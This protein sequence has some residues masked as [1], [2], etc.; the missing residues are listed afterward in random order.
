MSTYIMRWNPAISSSKI[1]EFR[2]AR[3]KWP[4][5]FCGDWSIYEWENAHARDKYIMVRVGDEP[6]G[7]VYHGEFLSEPYTGDDWAGSA[8]KRHYVDISIQHPC[9]PWRHGHS[10]ELMSEEVERKFWG[11]VWPENPAH[12][13]VTH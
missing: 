1:D 11:D 6:C 7:V 12:I 5:G 8:R 10:G 13:S 3:E 9:D 2:A 4:D